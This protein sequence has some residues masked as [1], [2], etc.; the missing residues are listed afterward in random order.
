MLFVLEG[1]DGAGKS[2]QAA[3]LSDYLAKAWKVRTKL[4]HFPR[5]DTP[6][7]GELIAKFLRG[8]FGDINTVQPYLVALL[9]AADRHNAAE[10][11]RKWI[12][13][14]YCVMVDR[15]VYSN[16]AYQCAKLDDADERHALRQ[17]ILDME[18][19]HFGIPKPRLSIFLDVPLTHVAEKLCEERAGDDRV[20]L[21]GKKDIH[22]TSMELQRKVRQI[23]LEQA[24]LDPT[25]KVIDCAD[26]DRM[27]A[28]EQIFEQ[29]KALM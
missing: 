22:E 2:T 16:I 12:A 1:L 17:F 19:R 10:T 26:G 25:F 15:Y 20:Y 21:Q 18:Y 24:A 9:F 27:L 5:F 8:D 13:G 7:Y 6:V 29:L 11:I 4:Q 3:M 14:G 28:P 23:Y